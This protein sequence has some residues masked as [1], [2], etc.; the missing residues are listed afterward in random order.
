MKGE[1]RHFDVYPKVVRADCPAEIA[2]RPRFGGAYFPQASKVTVVARRSEATPDS[3]DAPADVRLEDGALVVRAH[4]AGEQEHRLIVRAADGR[5]EKPLGVF[6]VYSVADDLLKL[7]PWKGDVHL[8]SNR[9]DGRE[10][11]ACVAGACRRIGL[12]FMAVTDHGRYA[13]SLEAIRAFEGLEADLKI[14][15]GEEVHPPDNPIHIINFG[16]RRSVNELFADEEKYTSQVAQIGRRLTGLAA[17]GRYQYASALWCYG[18]IA[19]AGGLSV[20]CHPYWIYA[21][22]FNVSESLIERHFAEVPF[23]AYEVI[24]GYDPDAAEANVLQSARYYEERAAG[25]R[26]G[27]VGASD[28]H[29]CESGR[30]FG[31]YYTIVFAESAELGDLID[32][33]RDG[34]S[35]AVEAMPGSPVR[36]HGPFRLVKFAQFLLRELLPLHDDLCVE[37]GR[38]MLACLAGQAGA[39]Q[40]LAALSGRV[41]RLYERLWAK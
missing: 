28:A 23:D 19:E 29:G 25:R 3:D 1:L 16:G 18:K 37:E 15:P 41:A 8:H 31:W 4:F 33:I 20:F 5:D 22:H 6:S 17:E 34:R 2:I 11:P 35:V 27:I 40:S 30:L 14:Y 24:G 13:P 9:S 21:E 26:I 7:R 39:P 10:S 36:A 12:D 38:L 32:A